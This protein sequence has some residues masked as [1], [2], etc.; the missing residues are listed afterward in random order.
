[1]ICN[2]HKMNG[3]EDNAQNCWKEAYNV[4]QKLGLTNNNPQIAEVMQNIDTNRKASF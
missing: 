2:I 4:F 3:K 1:M